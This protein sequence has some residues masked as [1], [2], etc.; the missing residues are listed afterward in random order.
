MAKAR[1]WW[2]PALLAVALALALALPAAIGAPSVPPEPAGGQA[3]WEYARVV[4]GRTE[5][6]DPVYGWEL[7]DT[8]PDGGG[9]TGDW[10]AACQHTTRGEIPCHD[11]VW[12]WW[13]N[14]AQCYVSRLAPQP[15]LGDPLWNDHDPADGSV[16]QFR[17]PGDATGPA[18]AQPSTRLEFLPLAPK[19]PTVSQVARQAMRSLELRPADIGT[20]PGPDGAGLVGVPVWL[21]TGNV[22]ATWGPVSISVPG[23]GIT[24][25]AEGNAT[26]IEW[27][28]GDGRTVVCDGPGTPYREGYDGSA[29]E[30][31]HVYA[32]PSGSQPDGRYRVTATTTWQVRWWV[33]PRGS[34][35]EGEDFFLREASTSLRI[36]ELHVVTS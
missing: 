17:C 36:N 24:V 9:G 8:C 7:V 10:E 32:V 11:P 20:A 15:P 16:Y 14:A 23:P 33:E 29:P 28:M 13:S 35:A 27:A 4:T 3:C 19:L 6:G 34:G 30:C 31:G 1:I 5:G 26:R 2:S 22:E 25:T 12:G 18:G 21:W